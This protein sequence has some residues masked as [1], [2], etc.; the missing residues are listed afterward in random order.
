[1]VKEGR[2]DL[3]ILDLNLP[4]VNGMDLLREVRTIRPY[5]AVLILTGRSRVEDLVD[6]LDSGADDYLTKPFA[7]SELSAR[8]RALLR[9]SSRP[10][11][12]VLCSLDLELDRIRRI[13]YRSGRE[14]ELTPK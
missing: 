8:V 7:F 12:P 2:C 10:F 5:L 9:R 11:E 13:V 14:I 6:V 4:D 3:L 1:M